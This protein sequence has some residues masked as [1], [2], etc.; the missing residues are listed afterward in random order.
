MAALH[1]A[2]SVYHVGVSIRVEAKAVATAR[3]ALYNDDHECEKVQLSQVN[4]HVGMMIKAEVLDT[5]LVRTVFQ[6]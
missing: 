2:N 5:N 1:H 4:I 6:V 3:A